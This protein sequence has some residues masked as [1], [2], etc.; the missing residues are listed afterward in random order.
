MNFSELLDHYLEHQKPSASVLAML[1][2]SWPKFVKY[3]RGRGL[4][5][6]NEI[7]PAVLEDFYKGLLWEPNEKGQWYKANSVDQFLRRVRQVLRW[8]AAH[9][10]IQSDPTVGLL[11]PRPVQPVR[12]PLTWQELQLLLQTPDRGTPLGL[13][14]ALLLQ[15]LAESGLNVTQLVL[16][17]EDSAR[18]LELEAATQLLLNDYLELARPLLSDGHANSK[19]LFIG[20]FGAP[21][22]APAVAFRLNEMARQAGLG[23]CLP[24]RILRQSYQ[25]ALQTLSERHP[26]SPLT[27]PVN[28]RPTS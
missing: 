15:L 21:L 27:D 12:K 7:T 22:G 2:L 17:T 11:L 18:Q 9:D 16:L 4:A 28:R 26:L 14:D 24:T 5:D 1:R 23:R 10:L 19:R 13:R 3:C 8:S 20:K 6:G 25:V